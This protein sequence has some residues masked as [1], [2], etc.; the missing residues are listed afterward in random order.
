MLVIQAFRYHDMPQVLL[1]FQETKNKGHSKDN[2]SD[3]KLYCQVP[4]VHF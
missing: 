4:T 2:A 1:A 3:Y